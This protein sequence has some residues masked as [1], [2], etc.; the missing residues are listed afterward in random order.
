MGNDEVTVL[1]DIQKNTS[2]GLQIITLNRGA[3]QEYFITSV[4]EGNEPAQSLFQRMADA[5]RVRKAHVISH[6]VFGMPD[7]DG[8]GMQMLKD[9]MGGIDAPNSMPVAGRRDFT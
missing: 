6:E 5:V 4:P 9:T 3:F 2:S 1:A 7:R 8:V